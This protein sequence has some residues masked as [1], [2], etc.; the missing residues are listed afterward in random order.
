MSPTELVV[1]KIRRRKVRVE[2]AGISCNGQTIRFADVQKVYWYS[3]RNSVNFVPVADWYFFGMTDGRTKL[4]VKMCAPFL[5]G[6]SQQRQTFTELIKISNQAV[7]PVIADQL[8]NRLKAGETL[9][10]RHLSLS[11]QGLL[12]HR[13]VRGDVQLSWEQYYQAQFAGGMLRGYMKDRATAKPKL[14]F[15]LPMRQPN[16]VVLPQLLA[17]CAREWSNSPV[18][19]PKLK[20]Q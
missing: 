8:F 19:P 15:L 18:S 13:K 2:P 11:R 3:Q 12:I 9:R 4:S 10:F 16:I 7:E 14:I 17:R 5:V 1:S 6:S 20:I